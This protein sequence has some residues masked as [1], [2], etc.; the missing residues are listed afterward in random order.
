MA[1][2]PILDLSTL[3]DTRP[4]IRIDGVTYHLKSPEELTLAESQHFTSWGKELEALGAEPESIGE[5]E[6]LVR[7][8][9]SAAVADV[10]ADVL[11]KLS[12]GQLMSVIQV[13]IGL[14][15][16]HRLRLVGALTAQASRQTGANSSR[17][18]NTPLA[19]TPDGG[20]TAPQPLS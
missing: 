7:R 8:V 6:M 18:S 12:T 20:S 2:I 19:E 11:A 9:A 14:Q 15:L 5:L 4:P 10:P 13:F 1:Q 3:T 16:A 17:A